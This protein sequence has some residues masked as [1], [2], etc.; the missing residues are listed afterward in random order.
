MAVIF[1][2]VGLT[3]EALSLVPAAIAT[4][5]YRES[6]GAAFAFRTVWDSAATAD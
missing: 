1:L 4:F 3:R 5:A 6:F 2:G